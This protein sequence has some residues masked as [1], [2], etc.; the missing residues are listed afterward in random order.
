MSIRL[1]ARPVLTKEEMMPEEMAN[2]ESQQPEAVPEVVAVVVVKPYSMMTRNYLW[3]YLLISV[4]VFC[5]IC[6]LAMKTE[7]KARFDALVVTGVEWIKGSSGRA[8]LGFFLLVALLLHAWSS[9]G[10]GAHLGTQTYSNMFA[11]FFAVTMLLVLVGFSLFFAGSY[12]SA[13]YVALLVLLIN[14]V[15][16]CVFG[17]WKMTGMCVAS[18]VFTLWTVLMTWVAYKIS[19]QNDCVE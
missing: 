8:M 19:I 7:N 16:T 3:V 17:Y 11:G 6:W 12:T 4:L 2:A 9:C 13:Y 1:G 15:S 14:L 5:I 10:V 18:V